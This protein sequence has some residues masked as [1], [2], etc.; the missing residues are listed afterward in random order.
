MEAQIGAITAQC[1]ESRAPLHALQPSLASHKQ[2][3]AKSYA[4]ATKQIDPDL[5]ELFM[6][7]AEAGAAA[8]LKQKDA[9]IRKRN[10]VVW[11]FPKASRSLGAV[12]TD[13]SL[14]DSIKGPAFLGKLGLEH[15]V[16]AG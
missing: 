3:A 7:A 8:V 16:R 15:L 13:A 2:P 9:A 4:A 5:Q 11:N 10:I 12:E 14:L 6:K 1:E